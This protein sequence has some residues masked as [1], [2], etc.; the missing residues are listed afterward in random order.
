VHDTIFLEL[1]V[2]VQALKTRMPCNVNDTA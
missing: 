2:F 1:H